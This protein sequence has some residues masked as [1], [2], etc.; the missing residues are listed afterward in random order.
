VAGTRPGFRVVAL[1]TGRVILRN[2]RVSERG[3]Q[4]GS[5]KWIVAVGAALTV[6]VA[7]PALMGASPGELKTRSYSGEASQNKPF[8]ISTVQTPDGWALGTGGGTRLKPQLCTSKE[9][10]WTVNRA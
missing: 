5:R 4:M 10:T 7:Q 3:G 6:L 1:E 8:S 9:Q 2:D